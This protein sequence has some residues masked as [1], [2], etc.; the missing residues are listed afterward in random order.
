MIRAVAWLW[1][2][3]GTSA[4]EGQRRPRTAGRACMFATDTFARLDRSCWRTKYLTFR[5]TLLPCSSSVRGLAFP[6]IGPENEDR[7]AVHEHEPGAYEA[8]AYISRDHSST[9]L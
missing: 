9:A 4:N 7:V 3:P 6:P 8:R 5:V 2:T 1:G